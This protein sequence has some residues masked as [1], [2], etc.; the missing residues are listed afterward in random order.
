SADSIDALAR[1]LDAFGG[2]DVLVQNAGFGIFGAAE[3]IDEESAQRQFNVNLFGPL[4]LVR[5][6]LPQLRQ[7]RGRII[8]IGSLAGRFALPFQAHYSASK[9]A[10]AAMS[11]ALR[12]ELSPFGIQVTCVEPGDF[13]T[14]FTSARQ[15]QRDTSGLYEARLRRCLANVERDER[16]GASPDLL[17]QKVVALCEMRA[18]P[19]HVPVGANAR[20]ICLLD[21][22]IPR[23][24]REW[25]IRRL[26]EV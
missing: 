8:W 4:A 25:A 3:C 13:A 23:R 9:A 21:W 24:L 10:V 16:Q 5:R 19:A 26:Y 22:L 17:A 1:S 12:L 6:L 20:L 7:R 14:G 15:S 11:D 2:V 18:L